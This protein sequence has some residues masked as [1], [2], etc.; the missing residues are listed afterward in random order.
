MVFGP[1][2]YLLFQTVVSLT[3]WWCV[4]SD[5]MDNAVSWLFSFYRSIRGELMYIGCGNIL[6]MLN[7]CVLSA[8][9]GV[10]SMNG[11]STFVVIVFSFVG[12]FGLIC[13]GLVF[14]DVWLW[15]LCVS[16][17]IT[18]TSVCSFVLLGGSLLSGDFVGGFVFS[19]ICLWFVLC[20]ASGF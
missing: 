20:C 6:M 2:S 10:G 17:F 19:S 3:M 13:C 8:G 18:S 12:M 1:W 14:S 16:S 4:M 9:M 11:W 15:A 5:F 7:G